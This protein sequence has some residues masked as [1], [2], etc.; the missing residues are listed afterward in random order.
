MKNRFIKDDVVIVKKPVLDEDMHHESFIDTLERFEGATGTIAK[1]DEDWDY[2][3]SIKFDDEEL[4]TL[5]ETSGGLLWA[6][7]CLDFYVS[8]R[9]YKLHGKDLEYLVD[10]IDSNLNKLDK[11]DKEVKKVAKSMKIMKQVME[12][13][14]EEG[15]R[16]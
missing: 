4:Q 16:K 1:V 15:G 5:S 14:I 3:Y 10:W 12:S 7:E 6:D 11:I 9:A 8:E 2:P 13:V